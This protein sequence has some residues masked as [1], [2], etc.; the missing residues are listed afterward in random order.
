MIVTNELGRLALAGACCVAYGAICLIPWRHW[1]HRRA[2]AGAVAAGG[3]IVAYASQT[4][5]GEELAQQTA[6]TLRLAGIA[7]RLCE[8]SDLDAAALQGAERALFIASTY[9]EGDA[10]DGGASFAGKL[11]TRDLPLPRLHYAVLALGD[12]SYAHFCGFGRALDAW[13]AAQGAQPLFPRV[14]VDR[15]ATAD[16]A[17]WRQHLS[18]MAGTS[19]AP[20]WEAPAFTPWRLAARRLLNPGSAGAPVYHLELEPDGLA[21]EEVPVGPA[22]REAAFTEAASVGSVSQSA[23]LRRSATGEPQGRESLQPP[24]RLP[25]WQSGDLV[26]VAP[27]AEPDRPREYSIASI[28][29][30]GR[31]H[32]LVRLLRHADGSTGVASGWL[33]EQAGVGG[34]VP[35]RLRQHR[36]FRLEDNATQPLILIG[37]GSGIAGLRGHLRARVAAGQG[38]NWLL[39]GE[40][41][42]AHDFHYGEELAA[43]QQEG[44]LARVD[45]AFSRDQPE[46][47]YVQDVLRQAGDEL[48]AWINDG[49]AVY[50]CGSLEGMAGGVDRTLRDLLGDA[51][52]DA[53]A[54]AGRYRR[55]VY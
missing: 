19:D 26:Q 11:M 1:R 23:K 33:C 36:R 44:L 4:G 9:G 41:N 35:L 25:A 32:L 49:A 40:R 55:D 45:L 7:V 8:L 20:D 42:R 15:G 30:D 14:D 29:A 50:V 24:G 51:A 46:R 22:P 52:V 5:I 39:F 6:A 3:W 48:R 27:A 21:D 37:N 17:P 12:S 16:I 2:N 13:L 34:L 47:L 38:R 18:H 53:L 10:P 54:S 43:W 28:P 31:L